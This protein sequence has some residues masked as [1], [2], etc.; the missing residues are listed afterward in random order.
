MSL[1][2]AKAYKL[3]SPYTDKI[4]IG[5]TT[6]PLDLRRCHHEMAYLNTKY[7]HLGKRKG[8]TESSS[9]L[10]EKSEPDLSQVKI[11]LLEEKYVHSEIEVRQLEQTWMDKTSNLINTRRAVGYEY[12]TCECGGTIDNSGHK[13]RHSETKRHRDFVVNQKQ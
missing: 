9:E 10:F 8:K 4:Y 5:S 1:I 2:S 6:G 12:H 13:K 11:S 7:G 3:S